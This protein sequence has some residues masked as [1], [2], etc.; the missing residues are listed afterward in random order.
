MLSGGG[1]KPILYGI[2]GVLVVFLVGPSLLMMASSFSEGQVIGFPPQGFSLRWYA[3]LFESRELHLAALHSA[4][5]AL[6]CT[7]TSTVVGTLAAIALARHRLY[8]R[9]GVEFYLLLPFI[10]PLTVEAVGLLDI[11]GTLRLLGHLWAVGIAISA[12][13]LPFIIGAVTAAAKRLDPSLEDAAASCG[14]RPIERF[15]TVTLPT[16]GPG[17]LAG[18][19]LM[20]ITGINEFVIS[21]FLIDVR[22]M[23]L[24]VEIFDTGRGA[25]T[26]AIAA[27]SVLY[28]L[29]S[30]GAVAIVD[31][32]VG[33]QFILR[34]A[35]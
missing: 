21:A 35:R 29:V 3:S 34:S 5:V 10:I 15:V 26:P 9:P 23:T 17:I 16:L 13:N 14:A 7:V 32:L 11:F 27:L 30:L 18:A 6:V 31:R 28:T 22:T 12:A 24:P 20:F 19:L 25:P 8:F 33:I 1:A 4:I 2:V